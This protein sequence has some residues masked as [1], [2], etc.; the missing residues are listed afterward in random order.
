MPEKGPDLAIRA[1]RMAG[2]P[3]DL[4]GPIADRRYYAEHVQPLLGS[5]IHYRGHLKHDELAVLLGS[6]SACLVTP[7]W[8]EPYGLVAA[9]ALACGTPVC[10][11]ARGALPELLDESCAVLVEPDNV[12][13]LASG[14]RLAAGL[15]RAD[16]R[17][18][19][20]AHCSEE[21]MV[22]QYEGLYRELAA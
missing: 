8:D 10:G 9:E 3:L 11:F 20:V 16:A 17:L 12:S 4:V 2:L 18:H 6:A 13:A 21:Q 7:R 19:A 22:E 1:A 5:G 15:A 14:L